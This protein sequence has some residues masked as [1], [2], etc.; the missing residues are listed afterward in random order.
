MQDETA[1]SDTFD[2]TTTHTESRLLSERMSMLFIDYIE[3]CV[4]R[5]DRA[6]AV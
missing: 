6:A 5:R 4:A 3:R 2:C 1:A